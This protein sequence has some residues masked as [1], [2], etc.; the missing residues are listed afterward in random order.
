[1][2]M[3]K[4]RDGRNQK[5]RFKRAGLPYDRPVLGSTLLRYSGICSCF[6]KHSIRLR[7]SISD[8]FFLRLGCSASQSRACCSLVLLAFRGLDSQN[9]D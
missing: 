5:Q 4:N 6:C 2:C 1:M 9:Q 3:K 7:Y 8:R